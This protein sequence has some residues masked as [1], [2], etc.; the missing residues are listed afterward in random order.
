M[1]RPTRLR[2]SSRPSVRRNRSAAPDRLSPAWDPVSAVLGQCRQAS[3]HLVFELSSD[4]GPGRYD[5]AMAPAPEPKRRRSRTAAVDRQVAKLDEAA[6]K[7]RWLVEHGPEGQALPPLRR[8]S[9]PRASAGESKGIQR[10]D[11]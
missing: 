5:G 9:K 4:L 10:H 11:S 1:R 2:R 3:R 6:E 8:P 7:L